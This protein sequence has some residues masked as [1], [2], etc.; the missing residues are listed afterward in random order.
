HLFI[1]HRGLDS[2][3]CSQCVSLLANLAK[4]GRTVVATIHTPS[5]LL[6]EKF[7]SLYALAKGHC[8]YRG[9]ISRLVPHLASLGLPCP[10]YHNPADFLMEV[11]IGEYGADTTNH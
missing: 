1:F 3:S 5:A 4:Q 7:D 11:A 10:A 8:I 9:S 6:F 2:S